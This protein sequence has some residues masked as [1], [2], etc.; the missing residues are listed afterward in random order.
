M[1]SSQGT[2]LT[3]VSR[4][5]PLGPTAQR[6]AFADNCPPKET[7]NEALQRLLCKKHNTTFPRDEFSDQVR[8]ARQ[9]PRD[10]EWVAEAEAGEEMSATE[11]RPA[12]DENAAEGPALPD[13]DAD[14]GERDEPSAPD[15]QGE[16]RN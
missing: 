10:E 11:D 9:R 4:V 8:A 3:G 16:K 14:V 12:K 5:G 1:T 2:N 13:N 6:G 15:D 7:A